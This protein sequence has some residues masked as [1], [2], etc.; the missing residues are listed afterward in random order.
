MYTTYFFWASAWEFTDLIVAGRLR[1]TDIFII[2]K[3]NCMSEYKVHFQI[4][5]QVISC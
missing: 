4:A 2:P 5:F 3:F 1:V